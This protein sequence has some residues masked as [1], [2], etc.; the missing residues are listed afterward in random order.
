[1]QDV[2][3][4][5]LIM[6]NFEKT[7]ASHEQS[8]VIVQFLLCREH[9]YR[10]STAIER[11]CA[12]CQGRSHYRQIRGC[13]HLRDEIQQRFDELQQQFAEDIPSHKNQGQRCFDAITYWLQKAAEQKRLLLEETNYVETHQNKISSLHE[14]INTL[15]HRVPQSWKYETEYANEAATSILQNLREDSAYKALLDLLWE[16]LDHNDATFLNHLR[17]AVDVASTDREHELHPNKS[18]TT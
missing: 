16:L 13:G 14:R 15:S 4:D 8:C 9:F 1:M 2:L 12:E 5:I 18:E 11:F 17:V 7:T 3:P 10:S 6:E